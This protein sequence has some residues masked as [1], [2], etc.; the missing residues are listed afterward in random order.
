MDTQILY[1]I[2]STPRLEPKVGHFDGTAD[3]RMLVLRLMW[4]QLHVSEAYDVDP[5]GCTAIMLP[6]KLLVVIWHHQLFIYLL[7]FL[8]N[9][10][11]CQI[12]ILQLYVDDLLWLQEK[13]ILGQN[14]HILI[15]VHCCPLHRLLILFS[16]YNFCSKL[17]LLSVNRCR[18]YSTGYIQFLNAL[19]GQVLVLA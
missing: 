17:Q 1:A 19:T 8:S 12:V 14:V 18:Y 3:L 7:L 6:H 16:L 11:S 5:L 4:P 13:C 2:F 9:A 15:Q 10:N